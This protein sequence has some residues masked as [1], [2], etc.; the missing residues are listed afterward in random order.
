MADLQLS[1]F[2]GHGSSPLPATAGN[3]RQEFIDAALKNVDK[4]V[5]ECY[6]AFA[7]EYAGTVVDFIGQDVTDAY[8]ASR[9][10]IKPA[11]RKSKSEWRFVGGTIQGLVSKG[12]FIETGETRDRNNGDPTPVYR[13]KKG[14]NRC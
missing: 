3:P 2:N 12:I 7:V 8:K 10:T 6:K 4:A 9:T 14:D 11:P 1:L 5:R 13:L